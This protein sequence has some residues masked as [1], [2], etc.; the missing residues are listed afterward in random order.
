MNKTQLR[1]QLLQKRALLDKR[2]KRS[3]D[4]EIQSRLLLCDKYRNCDT[5][6]TYVSTD[7]EIDTFG[8]IT[9]AFANKKRVAVPVTN[10]D[11]SLTFYYINSLEEL[12]IG[13][14]KIL[15][16]QDLSKEVVDFSNSIC[17]VPALCCDLSGNRVG[18]GKGCYDRFL[19][20]YTGEKIC[21]VYSDNILPSVDSDKTDVKVDTIVCD[22]YIKHT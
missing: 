7:S 4:L 5:V 2:K 22:S 8:L 19:K 17:V 20:A 3:L 10:D 1:A 16:P 13:R 11:Y 9:A 21:L 14:F 15:E 18:Y 12:K 6:L